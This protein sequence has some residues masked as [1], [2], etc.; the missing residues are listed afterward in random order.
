MPIYPGDYICGDTEYLKRPLCYNPNTLYA[1]GPGCGWTT[2][3]GSWLFADN[4]AT[5]TTPGSLTDNAATPIPFA[6]YVDPFNLPPKGLTASCSFYSPSGATFAC[7][8]THDGITAAFDTATRTF[9]F[10]GQS[11]NVGVP[12]CGS[13]TV[14]LSLSFTTNLRGDNVAVARVNFGDQPDDSCATSYACIG[15]LRAAPAFGQKFTYSVDACSAAVRITPQQNSLSCT[16]LTCRTCNNLCDTGYTIAPPVSVTISGISGLVYNSLCH[17]DVLNRTYTDFTTWTPGG[18]VAPC[19]PW[20]SIAA[21]VDTCDDSAYYGTTGIQ[22]PRCFVTL[23]ASQL[24]ISVSNA[25][26][27]IPGVNFSRALSDFK[28]HDLSALNGDVSYVPPTPPIYF[29]QCGGTPT[30]TILF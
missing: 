3:G 29:P 23:S 15:I 13:K 5:T 4:Y 21:G 16:G 27:Q 24:S 7:S 20:E 14:K 18:A 6:D 26:G 9:T 1:A 8:L 19:P 2:S 10:G 25:S 22:A 17:C 11:K 12:P 28:C 30:C